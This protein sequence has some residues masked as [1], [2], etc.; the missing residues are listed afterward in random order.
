MLSSD[1]SV[2]QRLQTKETS[3]FAAV[4]GQCQ[5]KYWWTCPLTQRRETHKE[6][7]LQ[8]RL[9][10]FLYWVFLPA[11]LGAKTPYGLYLGAVLM[12]CHCKWWQHTHGSDFKSGTDTKAWFCL[13]RAP[14]QSVKLQTLLPLPPWCWWCSFSGDVYALSG[15]RG[16]PHLKQPCL[17]P[18]N[19]SCFPALG[20]VKENYWPLPMVQVPSSSWRRPSVT[21]K[22]ISLVLIGL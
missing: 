15:A 3:G 12:L 20:M 1:S 11:L 6:K 7:A 16:I 4:A 17:S 2:Q 22:K 10:A 8:N 19:F 13:L 5:D 9:S 21:K 14:C 18:N